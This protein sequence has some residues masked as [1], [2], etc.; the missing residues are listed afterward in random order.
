MI[1]LAQNL[2]KIVLHI[3]FVSFFLFD[4]EQFIQFL[5]YGDFS[6]KLK[7]FFFLMKTKNL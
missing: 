4:D 5:F 6:L 1:W 2:E 3:F 7:Q